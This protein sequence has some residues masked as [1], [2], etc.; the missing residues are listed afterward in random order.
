MFMKN[1][2]VFVQVTSQ[3]ASESYRSVNSFSQ[4]R[5]EYQTKVTFVITRKIL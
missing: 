4:Y 1:C 2:P 3:Y 5:A